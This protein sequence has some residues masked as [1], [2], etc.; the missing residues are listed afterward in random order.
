MWKAIIVI[1]YTEGQRFISWKNV[2]SNEQTV[3]LEKEEVWMRAH[4]WVEGYYGESEGRIWVWCN[5]LFL[6]ILCHILAPLRLLSWSL[7]CNRNLCHWKTWRRGSYG[8]VKEWWRLFSQQ[9]V[10]LPRM[11]Q[12]KSSSKNDRWPCLNRG[13]DPPEVPSNLRHSMILFMSLCRFLTS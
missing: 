9:H 4:I 10:T 7:S 5:S 11:E 6:N 1:M 8:S 2:W 12:D 13:L 3:E